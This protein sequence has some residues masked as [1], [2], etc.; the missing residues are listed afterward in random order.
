M[1]EPRIVFANELSLKWQNQ[2]Y[3]LLLMCDRE[4]IPPLSDRYS[5]QQRNLKP[6][7]HKEPYEPELYY[8][9]IMQYKFILALN[10]KGDIV[11]FLTYK[12]DT[13]TQIDEKRLIHGDYVSTVIV[14]P[15][16][17]GNGI[18]KQLYAKL[19][20]APSVDAIVVRTWS[21]NISHRKVLQSLCFGEIATILNDRCE[22]IHTI[23]YYRM[24]NFDAPPK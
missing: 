6:I 4:F 24:V 18:S 14:H 11:G 2:I 21:T 5:A 19:L 7:I 12:P 17:R 8:A 1:F 13:S 3:Q 9:N 22:G 10:E 15:S 16:Y 23:Y 20:G